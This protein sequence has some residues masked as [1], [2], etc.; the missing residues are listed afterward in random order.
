MDFLG[1][2]PTAYFPQENW[3][4]QRNDV[5][6]M[7][8][9][10]GWSASHLAAHRGFTEL[11]N[12]L[13]NYGADIDVKDIGGFTPFDLATRNGHDATADYIRKARSPPAEGSNAHDSDSGHGGAMRSILVRESNSHHGAD[14]VAN[15]A[16]AAA[17]KKPKFCGPCY[18]AF[19]LG[20]FNSA[21]IGFINGRSTSCRF[22]KMMW[23]NYDETATTHARFCKDSNVTYLRL[24]KPGWMN[25]GFDE[26]SRHR[27]RKLSSMSKVI[28]MLRRQ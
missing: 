4:V 18:E 1:G 5:A 15:R 25:Y 17:Q 13:A 21:F 22:C 14:S 2:T 28:P 6:R 12:I 27:V 16:L 11:L 10:N 8:K 23:N 7:C 24:L 20:V 26:V 19:R 3:L 9:K